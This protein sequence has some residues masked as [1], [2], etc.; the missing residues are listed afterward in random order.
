[1]TLNKISKA[2]FI[3]LD[4]R[5]DRLEHINK[6]LPFSAERFPA[7]DAKNLE[8]NDEIEK[9]FGKNLEK[10]TKAE[11]ACSLSHYRLWKRLTLDKGADNYLILEDDAVFKNGFTN[12]WNQVFSRHIPKSYNLIYLGGCQPWN[13][14][15]YH[16]VLQKHNDYFFNIKRNN[17][18]SK[19]DHFWH[20]NASSYILS[21]QAAS[22]LCQWV[23]QQG[24]NQALDNF[25][26]NF[27]NKNKL[28]AAPKSIYHLNPLMSYQLHEEND[29]TEIDKNSDLRY[30]QEKFEPD[31]NK[32][33]SNNKSLTELLIPLKTNLIKKRIGAEGDGGYVLLQEIFND[34]DTV[35]SY[36]IDDSEDSDSFDVDCADHN[37]TVYMFDGTIEREQSKNPRLIFKKENLTADNL[38]SHLSINNNINKKNMILKMDIEGHEYPVIEKNIKLINDCFSMMCI[39]FHGLNNPNYYNYKNKNHVLELILEYY[40]IFHMHANNWVERKFEIPSVMEISFIRKGTCSS[41]PDCAYPIKDLDSPNCVDRNDYTL[42]WWVNKEIDFPFLRELKSKKITNKI[43][44][45]WKDENVITSNQPLIQKGIANLLKLNTGWEMEIYNDEDIDKML[46][47]SISLEDWDLIKNKKITEKTDLWRLLKTYQEGGL[48]ID[49][50]RYIDT[51]LSEII[52]PKSKI[53]L[54]TFQDIDFSQDF[55]LTCPKNPL[56]GRAI[57]NNLKYRREGKNL[58][59]LAVYSYMHSVSQILSG[60]TV[61]RGTNKEY[62]QNIRRKIDN[63]EYIQTYRE[64]GPGNHILFRNKN[65]DFSMKQ[66]EKDKADFYNHYSVTHWNDDTRKKHESINLQSRQELDIK[67]YYK[68]LDQSFI[69][70][71]GENSIENKVQATRLIE[72]CNKYNCKNVMEIGFNAGHSADLFL[73]INKNIKLTS[74]DIG[75]H[76]YVD[77]GKKFIDNKY[78]DRHSLILGD[79]KKTIPDFCKHNTNIKFDLIFI[80]GDHSEVGAIS[81][82]LNCKKL[83]HNETIIVMDDTRNEQPM[84]SW[85]IN[86]NKAWQKCISAGIVHEIESEDYNQE[87]YCARG[88][89]W[90]RYILKEEK[91]TNTNLETKQKEFIKLKDQWQNFKDYNFLKYVSNQLPEAETAENKF[92]IYNPNQKIAIVSLYTKEIADYATHSENSIKEYC[93]KQGY[94]FYIYREKLEKK[95]N[96]NW[97]KAQALLN[98]IDDHE[99][100]IWMD[101]D[102]L[103]FN[104]NKKLEEII[105]KSPKKFILATKDIGGNSMLNSGVL[106]FKSH[107]YTKNLIKRWRDFNGDKSSLYSSGGDQEV[108]CEILKKSD[109]AGFNRKIF[110]MNE[111]NTDPRL[112]N[113]DTFILH[114]MAYP[115]ELKKIFMGYWNN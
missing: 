40:D 61:E 98:H 50:D 43:H 92:N 59:F 10:F 104:P 83:S 5:E 77:Y 44:I 9:I 107:N 101:S 70:E 29:N 62:F 39:E 18:F 67:E 71:G 68:K 42:D 3:N 86:V 110:E 72:L 74:F 45:S 6:N 46:R 28:F 89:S 31:K 12:F 97:S 66:F 79:S 21:K 17:F 82:L 65:S 94:T 111:F 47:D 78:P 4:R 88:Q 41:E 113:N 102:T 53:V 13:K 19:D 80:D 20:M 14:P 87:G 24:M 22:I 112:V 76:K 56:I 69:F 38:R 95:S 11:I 36:G 73:G 99:Y 37:K 96:P 55:I 23:E 64:S 91:N 25:M 115:Q 7:I 1:M 100:I 16:K 54:P 81:D 114:F 57:A 52:N 106:F 90:G 15:H 35:Y 8:L 27:F 30:A 84:A 108:L 34:C 49:I 103:I 109:E 63:C 58:F 2:F 85:N 60:K 105:S 75:V 33:L 32:K 26:Q 51:P 48:Y 93:E